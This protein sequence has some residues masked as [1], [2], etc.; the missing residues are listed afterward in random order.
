MR[1]TGD[2]RIYM[3]DANTVIVPNGTSPSDGGKD[4]LKK[5]VFLYNWLQD[6]LAHFVG[7]FAHFVDVNISLTC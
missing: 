7:V 5:N 4:G 6:R 2:D 1:K 3:I